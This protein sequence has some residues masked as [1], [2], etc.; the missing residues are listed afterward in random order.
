MYKLGNK[1]IVLADGVAIAASKAQEIRTTGERLKCS[2]PTSGEWETHVN[3]RKSWEVTAS[4][5]VT[6]GSALSIS[7]GSSI[8][9]LLQVNNSFTLIFM[10]AEGE[11]ASVFGTAS[12][13]E[14]L[15]SANVG[16]LVQGHFKF[17]GNGPLGIPVTG[18]TLNIQQFSILIGGTQQI[19]PT[20]TPSDASVQQLQWSSSDESIATV[21]NEGNVTAIGEGTCTITCAAT[22]GSGVSAICSCQVS[23]VLVEEI[24]LEAQVINISVG[25]DIYNYFT[26]LPDNATNKQVAWSSSDPTIATAETQTAEDDRQYGLISTHAVGTCTITCAATDGSGVIATCE[27]NVI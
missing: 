10:D 9:D 6:A 8:L 20:I 3:K 1:F 21:D 25:R 23:P 15:I 11:S 18:I 19:T 14:V 5:L 12:L 22:D 24:L 17:T 27:V 4:Y 13:S 2:S 7:G 26:I 16:K